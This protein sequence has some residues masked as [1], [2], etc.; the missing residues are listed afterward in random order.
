MQCIHT[1]KVTIRIILKDVSMH[2]KF[3]LSVQMMDTI[4]PQCNEADG[5]EALS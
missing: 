2:T 3:V 5:G 4:L 1:R